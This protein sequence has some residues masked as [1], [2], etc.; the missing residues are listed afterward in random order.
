MAGPDNAPIILQ[1]IVGEPHPDGVAH[2]R[3][4]ISMAY[5]LPKAVGR[6]CVTCGEDMDCKPTMSVTRY[7]AGMPHRADLCAACVNHADHAKLVEL[8]DLIISRFT[9][10]PPAPRPDAELARRPGEKPLNQTKAM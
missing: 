9:D 2:R 3:V 5:D 10:P 1:L 7:R 8:L 6:Y 4:P